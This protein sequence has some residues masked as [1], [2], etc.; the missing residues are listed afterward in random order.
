MVQLSG[1]ST[2]D[3]DKG[4]LPLLQPAGVMLTLVSLV[5]LLVSLLLLA[6]TTLCQDRALLLPVFPV[7]LA[8]G[9]REHL[10]SA[11]DWV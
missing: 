10:G 8:L 5:V 4:G 3:L 9:Q 7:C 11:L 1:S 6:H 2:L